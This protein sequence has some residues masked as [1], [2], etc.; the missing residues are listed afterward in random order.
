MLAFDLS[1][2]IAP[3]LV[4]AALGRGLILNATGPRTVRL[5]PPLIVTRSEVDEALQIIAD[6]LGSL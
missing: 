6:A 1:D 5:V 2:D 4:N 3:A